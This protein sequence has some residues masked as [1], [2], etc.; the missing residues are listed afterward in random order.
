MRAEEPLPDPAPPPPPPSASP[1][2][3]SDNAPHQFPW[4]PGQEPPP[5]AAPA[6]PP[7]PDRV[8]VADWHPAPA[9]GRW[10]PAGAPGS[11]WGHRLRRG[12]DSATRRACAPQRFGSDEYVGRAPRRD[13]PTPHRTSCPAGD[14]AP[15]PEPPRGRHSAPPEAVDP[16]RPGS[17]PTGR[18]T[19]APPRIRNPSRRDRRPDETTAPQ[20]RRSAD[21][22]TVGRRAA[23]K[24]SGPPTGG[25]RRRRREE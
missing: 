15:P 24:A 19:A 23:G 10:I 20:R 2:R 1:S 17:P 25:G 13:G 14:V 11:N 18:R 7:Q 6:P 8:P 21:R 4:P 5:P 3:P 9:E 12:R 22:R 16:G